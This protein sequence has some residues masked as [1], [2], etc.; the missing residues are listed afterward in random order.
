LKLKNIFEQDG[1]ST[2]SDVLKFLKKNICYSKI[3]NLIDFTVYDWKNNDSKIIKLVQNEFTYG[4]IIIR[5]SAIG[6]DSSSSSQAGK[7]TSI[8]NI[9]PKSKLQIKNSINKVIQSYVDNGNSNL[10]N[11]ILI[12]QQ[13]DEIKISGVIFTRSEP[14]GSPYYTINYD[15]GTATDSV[16]SG[17][18]T[19][20]VKIFR[21]INKTKLTKNWKFL[22]KSV[23]EIENLLNSD[24]LDIEFG[25]TQKHVIIFQVRPITTISKQNFKNIDKQI[26]NKI[27][28]NISYFKK[29]KK[30]KI[31]FGKKIAFSDMSD[32]NPSEIIGNNP[33]RLDYSLYLELIM[34][35]IWTTGRSAIGYNEINN[36]PLMF[37]FGNKPYVDLRASFNSL[38][39]KNISK[40][41][42]RKLLNYYFNKLQHSP[43]LH[44]KIEFEI[45]FTC[46][47]FLFEH[48]K[49]ELIKSEFSKKEINELKE[50]LIIFT[51]NLIKN[52]PSNSKKL[53]ESLNNLS[54]TQKE[55]NSLTKK[56]SND[57]KILINSIPTLLDN[58]KTFGTK[59]FSTMARYAFVGTMLLE[60]L[61]H[62]KKI[63]QDDYDNFINSIKTPLSDYKNDI[64]LFSKSKITKKIFMK[65][66]GHLRP[67]TY[68]ITIPRYDSN[69]QFFEHFTI[70]NTKSKPK[71]DLKFFKN[72]DTSI[73]DVNSLDFLNF[74]NS[75][76]ILREITKFEFTKTL[77]DLIEN[78]AKA[79]SLLGFSR[80]D[81]AHLSI[82]N[83]LRAKTMSKDKIILFWKKQIIQEKKRRQV[84]SFL[85]LP[86]LIFDKKDFEVIEYYVSRPNYITSMKTSGNIIKLDSLK[87]IPN[88]ENKIILIE[89]ADPGYDWIFTKNPRALIT[90][91]GGLASH[92]AIRCA[93]VQLPAA[94]GCGELLF[95]KLLDSEKVLLD[96]NNQ[97]ITIL[98]N[99]ILDPE[100]EAKKILKL[101]GYIK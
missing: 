71:Y 98:E 34:K 100:N 73:L 49:N 88:L 50:Q 19:N 95:D 9:N 94:I 25:I 47:D 86:P 5:S 91:Y 27:L 58:C 81:V 39:P 4:K 36:Y 96:C 87:T 61:V 56:N 80:N 44:D 38:I 93:E 85:I 17:K 101:L 14:M 8:L 10:K 6:E 99:K 29:L 23:Q 43:F 1:E 20:T 16:T 11:K 2:K 82:D 69:S 13:S 97:Q 77:S 26:Q 65:K 33:N 22:L 57:F 42:Q 21:R 45:V 41:L 83:L 53:Q 37:Q 32:W 76:I 54:I 90:K 64:K 79:G 72:I 30:S 75:A 12:Q 92:M 46:Y 51:S 3:E 62:S 28:K 52:F 24:L 7:Y 68:D 89:N 70:K 78:I 40:K 35:S 48:R 74:V 31:K 18:T 60:S 15:V 67:G 55:I 66:Y 84:L 63:S 59:P